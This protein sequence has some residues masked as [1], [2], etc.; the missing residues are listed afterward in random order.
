MQTSAMAKLTTNSSKHYCIVLLFNDDDDHDASTGAPPIHVGKGV[1]VP[2]DSIL[3]SRTETNFWLR[4]REGFCLGRRAEGLL[5][6]RPVVSLPTM[7]QSSSLSRLVAT[8]GTVSIDMDVSSAVCSPVASRRCSSSSP[9]RP[10]CNA[11]N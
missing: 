6:P 8:F 4:S 9:S 7:F 5:S 11:N 1:L 3:S 2:N 10:P